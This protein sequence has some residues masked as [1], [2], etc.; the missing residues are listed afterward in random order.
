MSYSL[1]KSRVSCFRL[2]LLSGG[3]SCKSHVSPNTAPRVAFGEGGFNVRSTGGR[4]ASRTAHF[5]TLA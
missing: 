2:T 1:S 5:T 3:R 4:V